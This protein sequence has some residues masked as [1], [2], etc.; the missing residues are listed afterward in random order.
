MRRI[1]NTKKLKDNFL[2]KIIGGMGG[3]SNMQSKKI[4]KYE[5]KGYE[6][7]GCNLFEVNI[8]DYNW[9]STNKEITLSHPDYPDQMHIFEIFTVN[10][11]GVIKEFAAGEVSMNA[12]AFYLEE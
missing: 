11:N 4:W 8:F 9:H 12:W 5:N 6:V 2:E 10:I 3:E 1:K 7:H